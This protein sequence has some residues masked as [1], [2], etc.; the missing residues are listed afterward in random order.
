MIP[1]LNLWAGW[2]AILVGL[3]TG[4]TIGM[5]FHGEQWLGGYASWRRRMLRLVHISMVG[6]GLL[7]LAFAFSVAQ[8]KLGHCPQIG[9]WLFV[10]GAVTMPAVCGF[11]AWRVSFRHL[12]FVPVL[13]LVVATADLLIEGFVT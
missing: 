6:T 8:L 2:I 10:V 7:N 1:L 11:S 3:L 4:A 12:F 9:S 5:F 13:S